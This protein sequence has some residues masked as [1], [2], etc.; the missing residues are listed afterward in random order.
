MNQAKM[1]DFIAEVIA[2][3]KDDPS[4]TE[5]ELALAYGVS[6]DTTYKILHN[7]LGLSKKSAHWVPK[8]LGEAP[9]DK[10]KKF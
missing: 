7:D 8:L 2:T 9:K 10:R 5:N 3:V 4:L 6:S 1:H